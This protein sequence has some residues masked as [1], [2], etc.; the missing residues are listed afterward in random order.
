MSAPRICIRACV[1]CW[2]APRGCMRAKAGRWHTQIICTRALPSARMPERRSGLHRM[3]P[4]TQRRVRTCTSSPHRCTGRRLACRSAVR[5]CSRIVRCRCRYNAIMRN[6]TFVFLWMGFSTFAFAQN[7]P[8][9]MRV[10]Y[11]HS[12]NASQEIFS[13]DRVV[14]EPLGWPGN[15][16]KMI[17]DTN[18]GKYLFE[19]RDRKTNQMLYSRGFASIYGEWETTGVAKSL[20][21]TFHESLRFPTPQGPVQVILKKRD[22]MNAFREIWSVIVDP[23]DMFVDSSRPASPGALIEFLKS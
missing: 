12:G 2:V 7:A 10:D 4:R 21:H 3:C 6:R 22:R 20:N 9:T 8:R 1:S 5:A 17:D 11:Y 14:V 13:L 23:A 15:L 16:R 18:L 19:V